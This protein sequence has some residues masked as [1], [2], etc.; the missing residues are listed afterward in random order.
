MLVD[1]LRHIM[2]NTPAMS[3]KDIRIIKVIIAHSDA[4]TKREFEMEG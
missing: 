2:I 3:E 4:I 1:Q